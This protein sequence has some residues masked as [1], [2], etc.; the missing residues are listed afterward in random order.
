MT[1][2]IEAYRAA[3]QT[4]AEG[5][6]QQELTDNVAAAFTALGVSGDS[7]VLFGASSAFPHGSSQPQTLKPGDIILVD[8][9]CSVEGYQSDITR[10]TVFGKPTQ[11][12]RDVWDVEKRDQHL[13]TPLFLLQWKAR[14]AGV[15]RRNVSRVRPS[16]GENRVNSVL[17]CTLNKRCGQ[18]ILGFLDL[19]RPRQQSTSSEPQPTKRLKLAAVVLCDH[20]AAARGSFGPLGG[21]NSGRRTEVW[22][23]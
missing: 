7:L 5:M 19:A 23:M 2:R 20:V 6:T 13:S 10:T 8:G 4:I 15:L 17:R 11:R 22:R 16:D 1:L 12:Q 3:F 9:G 18:G 21:A 14:G